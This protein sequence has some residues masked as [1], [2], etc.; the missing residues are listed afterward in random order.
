MSFPKTHYTAQLLAARHQRTIDTFIRQNPQVLPRQVNIQRDGERWL[1]LLLGVYP[2]LG[3]AKI[4]IQAVYPPLADAPW[5][6]R[7][8]P[9]QSIVIE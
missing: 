4:A 9:I 3:D 8:G 2:T 5:I 6:R 7:L 1:L